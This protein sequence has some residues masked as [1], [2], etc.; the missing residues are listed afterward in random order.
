MS[1]KS[2]ELYRQTLS[3][4]DPLIWRKD[5]KVIKRKI[6]R[7]IVLH[8]GHVKSSESII[9]KTMNNKGI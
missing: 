9:I 5:I 8:S 6:A 2:N 4:Y 7:N 3:S 1:P